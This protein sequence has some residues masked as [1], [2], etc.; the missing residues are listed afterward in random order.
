MLRRKTPSME[1]NSAD[2]VPN[3][4]D[5]PASH[6][7][8]ESDPDPLVEAMTERLRR[9][10]PESLNADE[11]GRPVSYRHVV[12]AALS[13]LPPDVTLHVRRLLARPGPAEAVKTC[14]GSSPDVVV[15]P[16][17]EVVLAGEDSKPAF[18]TTGVGWPG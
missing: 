10:F 15:L 12:R 8:D 1:V 4:A 17:T 9:A 5:A 18:A 2:V 3:G 16:A 11:W 6:S 13:A 14:S 7:R